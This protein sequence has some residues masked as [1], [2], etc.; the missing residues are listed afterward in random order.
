MFKLVAKLR[1]VE[2]SS[3]LKVTTKLLFCT[4]DIQ[5]V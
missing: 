2:E 5:V 4:H 3:Q 1:H